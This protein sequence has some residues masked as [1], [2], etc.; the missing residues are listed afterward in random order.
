M[1]GDIILW[2]AIVWG[3]IGA[4]SIVSF[5]VL[6]GVHS[7]NYRRSRRKAAQKAASPGR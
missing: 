4:V 7:F 6:L 5:G 3:A 1:L 2:I